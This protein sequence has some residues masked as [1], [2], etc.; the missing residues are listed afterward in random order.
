M[1]SVFGVALAVRLAHLWLIRRTPFFSVLLGDSAAYDTWARQLAGGDWV[2]REVFYQAPLY[3]YFLGVLYALIG[4]NLLAIR[5][6][7]AVIGSVSCVLVAL[8]GRRLMSPQ[9]GLV[10]GL[11]LAVYAPAIFADALIQKSVLDVFFVCLAL[12]IVSHA[13][14]EARLKPSAPTDRARLKPGTMT[15]TRRAD[16]VDD[17]ARRKVG[18]TTAT[19]RELGKRGWWVAL[20]IAVGFLSLTR[21]NALVLVAVTALW[22]LLRRDWN[23]KRRLAHAGVLFLGAALVLVPVAIRNQVVGGELA[24]TTAQ[25]GPNLFIGNNARSDGTYMSL[26]SGHGAPEYERQDATELAERALGRSLTPG[27]VSQYWTGRALAFVRSNPLAWLRLVGRKCM[28]LWNRAEIV[29]TES[30]ATHEDWSP[31]LRTLA[32]VTHFGTLVPLAVAGIWIAWPDRKRLSLLYTMLAAYAGSVVVF[33]VFAR[34]RYPLVPML[35]LPA[36]AGL[37]ELGRFVRDRLGRAHDQRPAAGG[38]WPVGNQKS[39]WRLAAGYW[40][41]IVAVAVFCNWPMVSDDLM[42]A[43]TEHNLATALQAEGRNDEASQHYRRAIAL[44]PAYAPP[45]SNLGTL[46]RAEGRVDDAIDEYRRALEIQPDYRSARYNLANALLARGRA[47][48]AANE[49]RRVLDG[50]PQRVDAL[51]NLGIAL[52]TA[53]RL[54]EAIEAFHRAQAADPTSAQ[55]H[56]NLAMVMV[57]LGDVDRAIVELQE[58][59][60]LKLDFADAR[61]NLALAREAQRTGIRGQGSGTR[62]RR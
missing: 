38:Q 28:L 51:N 41:L 26:R 49:F 3:P 5:I 10:A 57:D 2:G 15:V 30:Q 31:I 48:E 9:A 4:P 7:Q 6:I 55:A 56:Y 1:A 52:A 35:V 62:I 22:L 44:G 29:D 27:E 58:A 60:R 32:P 17:E 40:P 21:E 24:L 43:V 46:L 13:I 19:R 16:R 12:W 39:H 45:H 8:A 37:V 33:Y 36:A 34:Y 42:R 18:A 20:G 25:F 54:Q 61:Q 53:G 14:E 59:L 23:V 50:D 47:D 11:V